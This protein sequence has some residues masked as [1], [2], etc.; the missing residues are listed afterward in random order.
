MDTAC[1]VAISLAFQTWFFRDGKKPYLYMDASGIVILSLV[2]KWPAC[3]SR[4][5]TTGSPNWRAIAD[6][7]R[8][9]KPDCES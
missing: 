6:V 8:L 7:T 9:I 2:V 5:G 1:T 4:D 3:Q